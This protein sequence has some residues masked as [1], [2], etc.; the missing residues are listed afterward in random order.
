[1]I[2]DWDGWQYWFQHFVGERLLIIEGPFNCQHTAWAHLDFYC[3]RVRHPKGT[4]HVLRV[5]VRGARPS[6]S[7]Q[8]NM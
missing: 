7:S 3:Y 1:V 2:C 5:D 8:A 4:V 6:F